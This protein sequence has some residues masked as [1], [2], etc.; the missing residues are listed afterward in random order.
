MTTWAQLL[1]DIRSDLQDVSANPR[2]PDTLLFLYAKDAILD[3]SQWLPRRL[4]RVEIQPVGEAYP[5]P[6]DFLDDILVEYPL[7]H[8]LERRQERPGYKYRTSLKPNRYY[9]EGGNLY[10]N[11]PASDPVY[12]TY[13]A[14]HSLPAS[15]ADQT[16]LLTIPDK[17]LE[18]IRL[19]AKAKAYGQTRGRQA[20]LDRFKQK[21]V[22]DDNPIQPEVEDLMAE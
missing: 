10:L 9:L 13:H 2:Y 5:L 1:S 4:D 12:L 17:D 3:Y 16:F 19:Y 6:V 21:G 20:N 22:R 14:T 7:D 8:M 15:E 18:L 11:G